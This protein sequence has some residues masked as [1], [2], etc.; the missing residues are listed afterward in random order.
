MPIPSNSVIVNAIKARL[1]GEID[2]SKA[3][4]TDS[5]VTAIVEE[6]ISA[7]K[8]ATV[9][10]VVTGTLTPPTSVLGTGVGDPGT[11]TGLS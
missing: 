1:S 5:L 6:V 7:V 8:L 3:P 10:T 11:G 9:Q 2:F 4:I